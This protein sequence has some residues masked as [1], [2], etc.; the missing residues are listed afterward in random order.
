MAADSD[1]KTGF[2]DALIDHMTLE[3]KVGQCF[4]LA[5]QGTFVTPNMLRR[6]REY[7]PA[8]LRICFRFREK[9]AHHDPG[10]TPP[11]FAHRMWRTPHDGI[12]DLVPGLIPAHVTNEEYCQVLNR[13]KQESLDHSGMPLHITFDFEGDT[14]QDY[15]RGGCRGF[16]IGM[17]IARSGD[18]SLAYDVKH[19]IAR[20]VVP[21]GFGWSH[22]LV[23]DVNTNPLNP[24]ISTRSYGEDPDTVIRYALEAFRG[25]RDGGI[26]ITG[27]HFPG[28]GASTSDAHAGLPLIDLSREEM[29]VHLKPFRA[30]IDAGVP[31]IM[32]AHT[33]YPGLE[34]EDVPATLSKRIL[35]ELLRKEMGFE[36]CVT[37][38]CLG[39][40]GIVSRFELLDACIR[41]MNAGADL[42]LIRDESAIIEETIPAFVQAVRDGRVA[43]ERI[44]EALRR[45]LGVKYDYGYFGE[46][47]L[48]GIKD[49]ARAGEGIQDPEVAAVSWR[50][51]SEAIHVIRD[52]QELL[53]LDPETK[54]LLIEQIHPMHV[55]TNSQACH[56]PVLWERMCALSDTVGCVEVN[57]PFPEEDR[58]RIRARLDQVDMVVMTNYY[59]RRD[60]KGD[61]F[62]QEIVQCGKPVIIIT[63]NPYSFT[64]KP[65]YETVICTYGIGPESLNEAA[66]TVYGQ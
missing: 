54:V 17:G 28:R 50:A 37:T 45:S 40:G 29:E 63:N 48:N 14:S 25:A 24:E 52:E 6:I 46:E 18:P 16:P 4:V 11:E 49:P 65:E 15:P 30:L 3:Q 56:P 39:M 36:G 1:T 26:I 47:P 35:T 20:Q 7:H 27:K 12:K 8:G 53:P 10:C 42:M 64:V 13:L 23:L 41:A 59:G 62:V 31:A 51:A 55:I 32:S 66:K 19:A 57:M 44:E 60:G 34:P 58:E 33:L 43:E 2:I 5:F 22:S 38:D 21:V 61:D 9:D